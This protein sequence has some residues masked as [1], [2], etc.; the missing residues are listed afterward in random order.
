[1]DRITQIRI[2]NIRAIENMTLDLGPLTVLIGENG[3]GKST[4]IEALELLRKAAE[5]SFFEQFY[6]V[7]RGMPGLLRLGAN[8]LELG[9]VIEDVARQKPHLEYRVS[10]ASRGAGATVDSEYLLV[11]KAPGISETVPLIERNQTSLR[12]FDNQ[13]NRYI[14]YS[15]HFGSLGEL[16][17]GRFRPIP[18]GVTAEFGESDEVRRLLTALR[19]IEVHLG[20]DTLASW[21]AQSAQR[22]PT[23]RG[24]ALL[25]PV[26]RLSLLGQNLANAWFELRNRGE[27]HWRYTMDLVR[28]GLG[29]GIDSVMTIPDAGGGH[30]SL[31][32]KRS[33]LP[34]PIPASLL[35]DGQLSWLAFVA[36]AR[37]RGPR[38]LL[39]IDEPELHLHPALLGRVISLL[40][41]TES[42]GPVVLSTHSDRL[43]SLIEEP[44]KAVRVCS[45]EG[46]RAVLRRV[47]ETDLPA[48]LEEYGDFGALRASGFLDRVLEDLPEGS[49][50]QK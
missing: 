9:L 26:E 22:S 13:Q 21:A 1:M 5:P 33:D 32:L 47:S 25:R 27:S 17:L 48:W 20:F 35:S 23:L 29:D 12:I 18:P 31:A 11:G 39:A 34:E 41:E 10:L 16:M 28:L 46:N 38:S 24:T 14:D 40:T 44:A 49:E 6:S 15:Q 8:D 45:L 19:G 7:H 3:S 50:G 2:K 36:M 37:L 42:V 4:I 43:L 30:I